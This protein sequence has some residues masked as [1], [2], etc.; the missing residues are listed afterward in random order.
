MQILD[1]VQKS[2]EICVA[3]EKPSSHDGI[4]RPSELLNSRQDSRMPLPKFDA[5]R[6]SID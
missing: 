5:G 2:P 3:V 1:P 6:D 4:K